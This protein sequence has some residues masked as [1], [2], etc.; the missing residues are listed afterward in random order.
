MTKVS[1]SVSFQYL[2]RLNMTV[3]EKEVAFRKRRR[4]YVVRRPKSSVAANTTIIRVPQPRFLRP[5]KIL[6]DAHSVKSDKRRFTINSKRHPSANFP[7]PPDSV[8]VALVVRV[9]PKK[10]FVCADSQAVLSEF[11]LNEQF[12]GCFVLLTDENRFKL[13]CIS[14]LIAYGNA[15]PETVRQLIHTR[16]QIAIDGKEVPITANKVV[17]ERLGQFGIEGLSDIVYAINE[18]DV[19]VMEIGEVLAPFHF[20]SIEIKEPKKPVCDGGVTGWRGEEISSF[21]EAIL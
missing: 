15:A 12:D 21:I 17:Q 2:Y 18:G 20:R 4:D 16:A 9:S 1:R 14:H 5:E 6:A 8:K 7:Q 19:H 11:K 10:S 13:K 3:S